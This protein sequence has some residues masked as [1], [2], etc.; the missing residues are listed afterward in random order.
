M[1]Q[2][3]FKLYFDSGILTWKDKEIKGNKNI[4]DFIN[5][6][7]SSFHVVQKLS[8]RPILNSAGQGQLILLVQAS[9][10]VRFAVEHPT[11]F[12]QNFI[13]TVRDNQWKIISHRVRIP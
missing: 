10:K 6:L 4:H 7:P 11:V 8:V 1:L 13:I 9:G 3:T 5:E 2:F 12:Q